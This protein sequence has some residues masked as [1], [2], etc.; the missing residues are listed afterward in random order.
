MPRNDVLLVVN[1]QRDASYGNR[2]VLTALYGDRFP[3]IAFTVGASC[4]IDNAFRTI[5]TDWEPS[6]VDNQCA[7][8]PASHPW[9]R[10]PAGLHHFHPRLARLASLLDDYNYLVFVEDD[11]ILSPRV[12]PE[13]VRS[14]CSGVDALV[15]HLVFCDR[16]GR[17]WLWGRHP[18]GYEAFDRVAQRFDRR[19]LLRHYAELTGLPAPPVAYV[20]MYS[21]CSD[22]YIFRTDLLRRMAPDL[23][24][25]AEVW[26]EAAV[27]TALLHHTARL[28]P[29]NGLALW[30]DD[31]NRPTADLFAALADHDFVHPIKLL[32]RDP[33][34]VEAL[35][36]GL[37][38]PIQEG[39]GVRSGFS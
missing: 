13:W 23:E 15:V 21:A 11:C 31:R 17:S 4:S 29:L 33:R 25:L 37:G 27:P 8:C 39:S 20:P 16:D 6:L 22:G 10:H 34:E 36:R 3:E 30:G 35:Y 2:H 14:R 12:D 26:V 24:A 7:C 32:S 38:A 19:R 1:C 9:G 5:V 28:G 18:T